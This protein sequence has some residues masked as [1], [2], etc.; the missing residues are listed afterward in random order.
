M[1]KKK[2]MVDAKLKN[3]CIKRKGDTSGI[4]TMKLYSYDYIKNFAPETFKNV[5]YYILDTCRHFITGKETKCYMDF[6][7]HQFTE[8]VALITIGNVMCVINNV[9]VLKE[10]IIE[11]KEGE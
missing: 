1:E 6:C 2:L 9:D 4:H 3:Y 11:L 7:K 5:R 10:L 8:E